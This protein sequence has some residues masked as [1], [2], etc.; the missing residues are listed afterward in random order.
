MFSNRKGLT[1]RVRLF[2]R[3]IHAVC[4]LSAALLFA[5]GTVNAED[6]FSVGFDT[7]VPTAYITY[8]T[9]STGSTSMVNAYIGAFT[10]VTD[11]QNPSALPTSTGFCIDL[12]HDM[13]GG[14]S[15]RGTVSSATDVASQSGW[16]PYPVTRVD[17]LELTHELNYL[18]TVYNSLKGLTGGALQ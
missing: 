4:L 8:S 17:G 16:F 2:G 18:G 15:F 12:W 5:T 14:Q 1:M 10:N 9:S 13:S 3:P 11:S 7:N 6:T